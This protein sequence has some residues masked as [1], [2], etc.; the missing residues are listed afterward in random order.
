VKAKPGSLAQTPKKPPRLELEDGNKWMVV[1]LHAPASRL[2]T[3]QAQEYQEDNKNIVIDHTELHQTVHIFNCKNSVIKISGKINAVVMGEFHVR[4]VA[5]TSAVAC[6]KTAIVME[7]AVSSLSITSSP[8]FEVQITG[9]LPTVQIDT[10]DS[11]QMYLS[12]ACM[13][14]VEIITSK[15]S[16]I[17]ISV[18]TGEGGDFEERPVP[19][20]MKS[21]IVK[22]KLVTEIVEH[23]G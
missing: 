15:T 8:S 1:S 23:A 2:A 18:P 12:K 17:N 11:G 16:S 19:E 3:H 4:G 13:E 7:S 14:V 21:K 9:S 20:Q 6:K 22:G 10:T 5:L